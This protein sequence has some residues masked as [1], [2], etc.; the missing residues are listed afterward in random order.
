MTGPIGPNTSKP[1]DSDQTLSSNSVEIRYLA[2]GR[3]VRAHGV[4]GEVSMA[5]LTEFPERFETTKRVY[6]GNE[7]E[8]TPYDLEA[9]RWH[10]QNLLLT[11]GGIVDRTQAERL[12]NQLVQVPIGE[13]VALP[14]GSYYLYELMGLEVYTHEDEYL[15]KIVDIIET[16]ANDVYVVEGDQPKQILI[17]AIDDVVKSVD[18]DLG[19]MEIKLLDGLI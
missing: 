14:E 11:L 16:K 10:K 13:A 6:L 2:I 15:G 7:Y 1:K 5:V 4:R 19:K 9:Y 17:P 12:R 8:A 3:I 18:L